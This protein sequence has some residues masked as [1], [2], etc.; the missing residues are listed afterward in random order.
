[1]SNTYRYYVLIMLMLSY[2]LSIT[3][4]MI[5]SI[6]IEPIKADFAIS[7]TQVGLLAGFAFTLF[8][9]VLGI[10][11][12][13][14]ADRSNRKNIISAA[15]G[16]WSLMTALCGMASGFWT[17]F[18][19]RIGVGIGEAGGQPPAISMIADYFDKHELSRAMGIYIS[20]AILGTAGGFALGGILADMFGWRMTFI[21]LGL[22]GVALA[23][24]MFFSVKEPQRGKFSGAATPEKQQPVFP[25]LKSLIGNSTYI[26]IVLPNAMII[27]ATYAVSLWFA[28]ILLRNFDI[29]V[30]EVGIYLGLCFAAGGVPGMVVGGY[31]GDK[32]SA[33]DPRWRAWLPALATLL[34]IPAIYGALFVQSLLLLFVLFS[35]GYGLIVST[36]GPILSLVQLNVK[37][38]ERALAVSF[39]NVFATIVGYAVATPLAGWIS[40]TLSVSYGSMSLNIA[41]FVVITLTLVPA[42]PAYLFVARSIPKVSH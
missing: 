4:R 36:Q 31:L 20:G 22:P 12:A 2:L 3:D 10:P 32:L 38:T 13:R 29:S 8:Y 26:R 18:L 30:A 1:M 35:I 11:I 16:L 25:T 28:P 14:F 19:A 27:T 40:D 41:V 42:V 7:D 37:P 23:I 39:A 34:A 33:R 21:V 15:V 24:L 6:L 5:M 17:L 9:V